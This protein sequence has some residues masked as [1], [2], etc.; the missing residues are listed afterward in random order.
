MQTGAE[1]A[2]A[3]HSSA[4]ITL[5]LRNILLTNNMNARGKS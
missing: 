1:G 3:I 5:R 4:A 2:I